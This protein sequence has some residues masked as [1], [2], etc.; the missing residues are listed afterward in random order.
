MI[1]VKKLVRENVSIWPHW[2]SKISA[3]PVTVSAK[4][5]LGIKAHLKWIGFEG[6]FTSVGPQLSSVQSTS[7]E[8]FE[9]LITKSY[10]SCWGTLHKVVVYESIKKARFS[11]FFFFFL[12]LFLVSFDI[13]EITK[14]GYTACPFD[15]CKLQGRL[16]IL[17]RVLRISRKPQEHVIISNI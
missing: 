9:S 14:H 7:W 2:L 4:A 16:Y 13:Y 15:F 6:I 12:S 5:W 11:Y 8:L 3:Y 17:P 10:W 1:I